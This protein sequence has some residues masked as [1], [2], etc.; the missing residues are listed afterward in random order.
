MCIGEKRK[1]TIPPQ[2]AYGDKG[3]GS[4]IPAG[5]FI[6]TR[7][8][9]TQ[10]NAVFWIGATLQFDVELTAVNQSPPPQNVFKQ[11]DIDS[12]NQLSKEEV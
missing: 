5:K 6:F 9:L 12:D 4:V 10:S 1:L 8:I 11:I 2:L 3:A 7:L